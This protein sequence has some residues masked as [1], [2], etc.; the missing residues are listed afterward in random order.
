MLDPVAGDGAIGFPWVNVAAFPTSA[1]ADLVDALRDRA[2]P[3]VSLV[4][5]EDGS[6]VGHLMCSPAT[7][8]GHP[9]VR[10]MGLA[11]MA[12][13]PARQARGIGAAL[14]REAVARCRALG[15][16]GLIVLG[17]PGYYPRFGFVPASR[18]GIRCEYDAPDE[19]FMAMELRPGA[20]A[21]RS[22]TARY[23]PCFAD[24]DA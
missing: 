14:V 2:A 19:A 21:E 15:V 9:E 1:E 7:L 18:W 17:H 24:L 4:A 10:L 20:L 3:L 8:D 6:V 11:P 5:E 16:D 22:G 12:V 23:H 13:V